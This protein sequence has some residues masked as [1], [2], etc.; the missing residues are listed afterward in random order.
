MKLP[1][2]Y[3]KHQNRRDD[4]DWIKTQL[5]EISK[6]TS[7]IKANQIAKKYSEEYQNIINDESI[8]QNEKECAARRECNSRLRKSLEICRDRYNRFNEE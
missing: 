4:T 8:H 6:L 3:Y 1:D 7:V 5:I 2:K